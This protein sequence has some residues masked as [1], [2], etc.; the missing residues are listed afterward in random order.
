MNTEIKADSIELVPIEDLKEN[1]DNTN[2]HPAE[3][4]ERL[5]EIIEH[6][7]F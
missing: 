4:I 6:Q 7:G 2:E 5:I 1:P 3:Q